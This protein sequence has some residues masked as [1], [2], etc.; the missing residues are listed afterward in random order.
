MGS[1][2]R[3]LTKAPIREAII[4]VRVVMPD[5]M[6]VDKLRDHLAPLFKD[7]YPTV[8]ERRAFTAMLGP[9]DGEPKV[10]TANVIDGL[11]F[12]STDN[13]RVVQARLDGFSANRL[14]PYDNF[15]DFKSETKSRWETFYE[16]VKPEKITRLGFRYINDLVLPSS[17]TK[18]SDVFDSFQ[19]S[20]DGEKSNVEGFAGVKVVARDGTNE[21]G[22]VNVDALPPNLTAKKIVFDI[23]VYRVFEKPP[24]D[25]EL[26]NALDSLHTWKNDIF[27]GSLKDTHVKQYE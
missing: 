11:F 14:K 1:K 9:M 5:G 23:D 17:T 20:A 2:I 13:T 3:H 10:S 24:S 12:R 16:F 18:P 15:K 6:T 19:L 21:K 25:E 4:D 27:F 7:K 8:Q 22:H 26:W